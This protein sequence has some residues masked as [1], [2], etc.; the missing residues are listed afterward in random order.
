MSVETVL[1]Y[2]L[3]VIG[4]LL[5]MIIALVVYVF[6]SLKNE[7]RGVATDVTS[8]R[9]NRVKLVHRTDCRTTTEHLQ[10]QL[11]DQQGSIQDLSERMARAETMLH[12]GEHCS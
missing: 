9:D 2:A 11:D 7:V 10:E 1:A 5:T 4:V 3:G 6:I 8:L 12:I